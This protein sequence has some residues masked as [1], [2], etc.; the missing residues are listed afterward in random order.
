MTSPSA[1]SRAKTTTTSA[2]EP[3]P[4][5]RLAPSMTHASPSRRARVSSATES[6]PCPG[7]VSA[8]APVCSTRAI[9]G[10][11]RSRC[12]SEPSRWIARI[13]RPDWTPRKVPRL[14]SPRLISMCT[15]PGRERAHARAA[16]ALDV[17]ADEPEL[18]EAP[19]QRPGRLRAL[20]VLVDLGQ[21]LLVDELA[22]AEEVLPLLV[23]ELLAHEEVVR[24]QRLAE[25]LVGH[26]RHGAI[27]SRRR[28]SRAPCRAPGGRGR[29][30]ASARA[31]WRP[32]ARASQAA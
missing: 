22:R 25:M 30:A 3:L 2:S 6:E 23:A 15:R 11:Q 29:R 19:E 18:A 5:H 14:P 28:R 4:I 16:V 31:A 24:G 1:S 32:S 20:P 7:S 8:K 9:P 27:S 17:V 12:S 10:S 13:A 21:D 26:R